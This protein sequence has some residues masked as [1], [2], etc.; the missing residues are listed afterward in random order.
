MKKVP[1]TVEAYIK[2]APKEAQIALQAI[3]KAIKSAAPKAEEKMGYGVPGF[4]LN[5]HPLVYY[6]AFK[7]HVGLYPGPNGIK[8]FKQELSA[9]KTATG[10]VQL[11]TCRLNGSRCPSVR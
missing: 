4:W 1:A 3:R 2:A 6:A 8:A 10:T 7:K 11:S 9:Y 5:G